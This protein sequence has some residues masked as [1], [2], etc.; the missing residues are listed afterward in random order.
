MTTSALVVWFIAWNVILW[1]Q[2]DIVKI[3]SR[4]ITRL[5]EWIESLNDQVGELRTQ[6]RDEE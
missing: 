5:Y 1:C 2:L 4:R 3:Q 6:Q